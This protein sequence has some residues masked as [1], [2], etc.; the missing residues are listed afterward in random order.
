MLTQM[1]YYIRN[2]W[3]KS[4]RD[5]D[6]DLHPFW[7]FQD[8][9]AI[10]NGL[11]MK[12]NRIIMPTTL[13]SDMINHLH[14]TH[15]GLSSTLQR[16]LASLYWPNI[17]NDIRNKILQCEECQKH[18]NKKLKTVKNQISTTHPWR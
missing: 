12:G 6:K 18:A 13:R 1:D 14:D 11:I 17:Q 5:I 7:P 8:E 9:L 4:I 15:Q 16:A 10:L 3:P 2:G